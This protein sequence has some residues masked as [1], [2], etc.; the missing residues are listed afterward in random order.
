MMNFNQYINTIYF[1]NTGKHYLYAIGLFILVFAILKLFE[2]FILYRMKKL[3]KKTKNKVDDTIVEFLEHIGLPLYFFVS[4]YF[5]VKILNISIQLQKVLDYMLLLFTVYYSVRA[6]NK[7]IDYL[8]KK[9]VSKNDTDD[10]SLAIILSKIVKGIVWI[11]AFL[12]VLSNIGVNVLSLVAGIGVGG[13]AIAFALQRILEDIFSSFSIYFDKP[14]EVG[15]FIIIGDDLGVVKKIGLK[16]TR[17]QHLQ[18]QEVVVSNRELTSIRVHNYKK[19]EK[20]RISFSFG[21]EY[22]TPVK[23][24]KKINELVTNAVDKQKLAKLDRVHFKKFGDF[25]LNYEVVYYLDS[26]DYNDYMNTQ[27]AINFELVNEFNKNKIEFAF[28]TQTLYVKKN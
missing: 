13:I 1:G 2:R 23:K 15:D 8:T 26:K 19:M 28:P 18:G 21:V 27:Q 12:L 22:S 3:A 7:V 4:L 9:Q 17:I 24:L 11:I 5:S 20:R 10:D 16:S 14:F 25:S 6:I